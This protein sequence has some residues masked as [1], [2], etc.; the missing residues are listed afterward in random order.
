[1]RISSWRIASALR[2]VS[3]RSFVASPPTI[4]DREAGAREG[5]APD[6]PLGQPEL[7]ADGAH[8]VLEQRAQRLDELELEVLGQAADVVVRLDRRRA[9]AAAGLDDVGV[10][11]A[12]DEVG[13]ALELARLLLE[14]ADELGADRLALGLGLAQPDEPREEA[15]LGV[16]GDERDLEVVAERGDDLLALVLAHQAVVDEHA[17]QLV[18]DRAVDE[19]RRDRRVDPAGEPADDA[20]VADLGADLLDLLLDDRGRAPGARAAADLLEERRQHVLA[21]GR[22]DDLGVELDAVEAALDVL[23]RRDRR[24]RRARQR[25]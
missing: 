9:G 13:R 21:V 15:V 12:L 4:A 7:G 20:A 19:Q 23:E 8:L 6:E 25:A 24:L 14:D 16:D 10:E 11:R 17:R 1:M 2:S 5:L 18:A 22:V 3:R